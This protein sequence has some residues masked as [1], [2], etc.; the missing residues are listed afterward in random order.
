MH[1]FKQEALSSFQDIEYLSMGDVFDD[2]V[3]DYEPLPVTSSSSVSRS[4]VSQPPAEAITTTE[5]PTVPQTDLSAL[6]P[7]S[8][9]DVF[10]DMVGDN[11]P[12]PASREEQ[13]RPLSITRREEAE[14]AFIDERHE[15]SVPVANNVDQEDALD[16]Q[17]SSVQPP[18]QRPRSR[19]STT[20]TQQSQRR[21][22]RPEIIPTESTGAAREPSPTVII[23]GKKYS[24]IFTKD[25]L[26]ITSPQQHQRQAPAN[27]NVPNFKR[28]KKVLLRGLF[29][30]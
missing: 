29:S 19:P 27:D 17:P 5:V 13:Q 6:F 9:D 3:G 15:E 14:P 11:E 28:F 18:R 2:M 30:V 25:I 7:E 21:P 8:L 1:V 12:V 26:V 24:K 20:R 23:P 4:E 10:D 16:S 22:S